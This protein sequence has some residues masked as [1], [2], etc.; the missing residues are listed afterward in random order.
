M[1]DWN[2][3]DDTPSVKEQPKR[4]PR[5]NNSTSKIRPVGLRKSKPLVSSS[6]KHLLH[7]GNKRY[8]QKTV[9]IRKAK[10]DSIGNVLTS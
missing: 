1:V 3:G 2:I 7:S 4:K 5:H 10:R 9:T 6:N 8:K